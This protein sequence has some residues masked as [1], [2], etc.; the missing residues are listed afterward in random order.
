MIWEGIW[1]RVLE[2][3]D[4]VGGVVPILTQNRGRLKHFIERKTFGELFSLCS[5][6]DYNYY[7]ED[8]MC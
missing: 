5:L 3:I 2:S 8:E 4:T 6:T 1:Y 7:Q